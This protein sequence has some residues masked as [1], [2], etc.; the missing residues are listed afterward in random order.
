MAPHREHA[1]EEEVPTIVCAQ[2]GDVQHGSTMAVLDR[3]S[4]HRR[5]LVSIDGAFGLWVAASPA[6]RAL[7]DGYAGADSW[8]T[9]GHQV[10]QRPVRYGIAAV[11]D[12]SAQRAAMASTSA[13]IPDHDASTP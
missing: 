8:A 5:R 13:Y 2:A 6:R 12:A 11:A 10:A 7:L 3:A 1:G 9:D 4:A